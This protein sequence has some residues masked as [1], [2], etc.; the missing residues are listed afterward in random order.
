[1]QNIK[2][3]L[4]NNTTKG[5]KY[6]VLEQVPHIIIDKGKSCGTLHEL[7]WTK[8]A[9]KNLH[10]IRHLLWRKTQIALGVI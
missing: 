4:W 6:S 1:M 9:L 5:A 7:K 3:L 2:K 10:D 8:D